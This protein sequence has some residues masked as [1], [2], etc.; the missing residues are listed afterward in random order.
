MAKKEPKMTGSQFLAL[1][2][3]QKERIWNEVDALAHKPAREISKPLNARERAEWR[4]IRKKIGRGRPKLGA[5]GVD[6][7][8]VSVE[9]SLLARA[10]AF[11]RQRKLK[12]SEMV[13]QGLELL[14]KA[15][16]SRK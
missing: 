14:M 10:D 11:A 7:V 5:S 13:T 4:D 8:S 9:K 15:A 16:G 3:A 6:R 12:R 2:D 1:P